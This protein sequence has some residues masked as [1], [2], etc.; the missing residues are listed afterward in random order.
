MKIAVTTPPARNP[1][2][3]VA[4]HRRAG[5]HQKSTKALRRAAKVDLAKDR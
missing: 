5:P 1:L 4:R 3:A 2:V